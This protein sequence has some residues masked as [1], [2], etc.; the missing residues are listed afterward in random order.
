MSLK[1]MPGRVNIL[2][3]EPMMSGALA[4]PGGTSESSWV[5]HTGNDEVE[6]QLP[7]VGS[8]LVENQGPDDDPF[9]KKTNVAWANPGCLA[10]KIRAALSKESV[11]S[12]TKEQGD[13]LFEAEDQAV[14]TTSLPMDPVTAAYMDVV[15]DISDKTEQAKVDEESGLV[16][17]SK[18]KGY[19]PKKHRRDLVPNA[20]LPFVSLGEMASEGE[21]NDIEPDMS[22]KEDSASSVATMGVM[23]QN[24]TSAFNSHVRETDKAIKEI[25]T[26]LGMLEQSTK[27][28]APTHRKV[29]SGGSSDRF[30]VIPTVIAAKLDPSTTLPVV[31]TDFIKRVP[32]TE[33]KRAQY[34]SLVKHLGSELTARLPL[35]LPQGDWNP[36]GLCAAIALART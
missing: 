34:G 11:E 1:D 15:K 7:A 6:S 25:S 8:D 30:P 32:Y 28:T 33:V 4:E 36:S 24:L 22:I 31:D 10:D 19:T 14:P 21:R 2:P 27:S 3:S 9:S 20:S 17:V 23:M 16:K 5:V 12:Q 18:S 29:Y 26:R 35:P 13:D